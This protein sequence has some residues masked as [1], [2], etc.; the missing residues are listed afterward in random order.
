VPDMDDL[1]LEESVAPAPS[2]THDSTSTDPTSSAG[3]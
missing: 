2:E 1:D 3:D